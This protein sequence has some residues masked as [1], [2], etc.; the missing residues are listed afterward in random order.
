MMTERFLRDLFIVSTVVKLLLFPAYRSTDFEVHRNW[1]AITHSLP[2]SKWYYENTSEWTL[3]YPPFFAWFEKFL[4]IFAK[5]ADPDMLRVE[6][7]NYAS[8]TTILYQRISVIASEVILFIALQ[9]FL[10]VFGFNTTNRVLAASI[11]LNPGLIMVDN[12]HFQYNGFLFGILLLSIVEA[13]RGNNLL[14][15][16]LFAVLLNFKH[17][18][19]YLSPAYFVYLLKEY[20]YTH[21][22]SP[23][24]SISHFTLLGS[25][26]I[27]VFL[28]SFGPFYSHIPQILSRLFPFTRGLC[29]AYWAPNFW[30]LYSFADRVLIVVATRMGWA[31]RENALGSLTRGYVGDTNFAVLPIVKPIHTLL[32]TLCLMLIALG[33]LWWRPTFHRFHGALVLCGFSS[34]LF[35]WHVHEKA[36]LIVLIPFS[37]MA[38]KSREHL[39]I[40]IILSAAGIYSLFPLL[41]RT[42]ETSIKLSISIVWFLLVF[43]ILPRL[44]PSSSSSR[45]SFITILHPLEQAYL[46]GFCFLQVYTSILH[47]FIFGAERLEFLPLMLTSVYCAMGI[48]YGALRYLTVYMRERD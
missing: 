10:K 34:Y 4:S 14:S 38:T 40:F 23:R 27:F 37:L 47:S 25:S 1:L 45:I 5:F 19:L 41:F 15:G 42:A 9:R 46:A 30:A 16:I 48:V 33:V 36:I 2:I 11:F 8:N 20:C 35:G 13:K 43:A 7:L 39:R 26:V 3:D 12:I 18:F 21:S 22:P 24:F 17:I 44:L 31:V 6:N 29:H 32:L 28:L